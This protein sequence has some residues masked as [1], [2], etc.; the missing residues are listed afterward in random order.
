M[1]GAGDYFVSRANL[2]DQ[3]GTFEF[4]RE[5]TVRKHPMYASCF[6]FHLLSAAL[7]GEI[8]QRSSVDGARHLHHR[9]Q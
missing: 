5:I 9:A 4:L 6:G 3:E 2:P 1:G 7:G 8:I